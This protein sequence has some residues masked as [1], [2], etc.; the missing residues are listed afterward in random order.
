[1]SR[2]LIRGGRIV[3]PAAGRDG[4]AD[5]LVEEGRIAGIGTGL[6]AAGAEIVDAAGRLV[7]PGFIDL[8][9]HLREPGF[10]YKE[11]ILSGAQAA[12]AG[13]FAAVC[14]M[15]NTDP[16]NDHRTVTR[17]IADRAREAGFSRVHPIGAITKGLRGEELSEFGEMKEAGAVAV[18][19]DG[20]WV[21]NGSVMRRAL[22]YATLFDLPVATH[23]E[24]GS[25]SGRGAMNEG[26]VSTRLG[27]SA[28]PGE[29]EST[30]VA[31][32]I[33]LCELAG[34]RLHVCHV[35]TARSVAL[36]REAK[37]RGVRVTCE[38]TPHHL[39]L[40][41]EE[42][43]R[44]G[45][46]TDTKVNPPLRGAREVEALH[47]GLVDGTIDAVATD[48]APHHADEKAVDYESAP[49]GVIG[50]ETAA[51]LFHD[52]LVR[53]GTV[54]LARM[55]E[56]F[57]SGPAR[58]FSLPGG[59]LAESGVAD[60]TI[61]DPSAEVEV[62]PRAFRSRARNTPFAGARLTGAVAATYVGGREVYRRP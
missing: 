47:A 61:F 40:T 3:D 37:A 20:R 50:L 44:S 5:L 26:R 41:D 16:V 59:T 17:W 58:T 32:D 24:D 43:A 34:G 13:G 11:S 23:A 28:Q 14:A 6:D 4:I 12:A 48:H 22:E 27:L 45:F 29:A 36:V 8:H 51:A 21:A 55:V 25:L 39:F 52:R 46:S 49:F 18:S 31:R 38:V 10:E 30:A 42:V 35:S 53:P 62:D 1:M 56:L 54:T 57:S 2:I 9:V 60:V 15:A 19:D 7:F 33:A